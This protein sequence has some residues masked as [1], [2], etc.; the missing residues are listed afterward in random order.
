M[1][2][3]MLDSRRS[4]NREGTRRL[5][6]CD[7]GPMIPRES[8]SQCASA[9]RVL[10]DPP[11]RE[12]SSVKP[13]WF[14]AEARSPRRTSE[15]AVKLGSDSIFIISARP[16]ASATCERHVRTMKIESDPN[17]SMTP[18]ARRPCHRL[19]AGRVLPLQS[20]LN[21][22]F[23]SVSS[24]WQDSAPKHS[25]IN[26]V[27]SLPRFRNSLIE[28]FSHAEPRMPPRNFGSGSRC[29]PRTP[30]LRVTN[31]PIKHAKSL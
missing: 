2:S 23:I 31:R 17:Y 25:G 10:F 1:T 29:S 28:P 30:R 27:P 20:R 3:E 13:F 12:S 18:I 14:H 11:N 21:R 19:C 16:P 4:N 8:R 24:G 22:P 5:S 26:G 7:E 6:G 15:V 9:D